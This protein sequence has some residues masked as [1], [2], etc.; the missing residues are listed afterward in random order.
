MEQCDDKYQS[1]KTECNRLHVANVAVWS[2]PNPSDEDKGQR[3]LPGARRDGMQADVM[4]GPGAER[5]EEEDTML[6]TLAWKGTIESKVITQ[7]GPETVCLML[8]SR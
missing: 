7:A 8:F 1:L 2:S 6:Y 5:T 4:A 3:L